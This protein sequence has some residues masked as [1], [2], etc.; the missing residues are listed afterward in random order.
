MT[1]RR[2]LKER[3]SR[4]S[5]VF[6]KKKNVKTEALE[7]HQTALRRAKTLLLSHKWGRVLD[8]I[9]QKKNSASSSPTPPRLSLEDQSYTNRVLYSLDLSDLTT[10]CTLTYQS[11]LDQ[12]TS[13]VRV[14]DWCKDMNKTRLSRLTEWTNLFN[15]TGRTLHVSTNGKISRYV[16]LLKCIEHSIKKTGRTT[17][18]VLT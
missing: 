2:K 13:T 11:A 7:K 14:L 1:K 18:Q 6:R 10:S 16:S 17:R 15:A 8:D 3:G 4:A 5:A 12:L 9:L